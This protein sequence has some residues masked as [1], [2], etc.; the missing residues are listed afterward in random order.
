[1]TTE[2]QGDRLAEMRMD[3]EHSHRKLQLYRARA[4]GLRPVSATRMRELERLAESATA[5]LKAAE[6]SDHQGR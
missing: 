6:V 1:M 4:Y 3:A 5:R 2:R